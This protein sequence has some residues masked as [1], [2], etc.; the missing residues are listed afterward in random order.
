[1]VFSTVDRTPKI[2]ACEFSP[3]Y[4]L[5]APYLVKILENRAADQRGD[6]CLLILGETIVVF[7]AAS[8]SRDAARG[9]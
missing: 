7:K 9:L 1:M 6:T 8:I 5:G 2:A 4:S 3:R